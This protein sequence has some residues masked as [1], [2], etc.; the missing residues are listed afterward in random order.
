MKWKDSFAETQI[1]EA[2]RSSNGMGSGTPKKSIMPTLL[3]GLWLVALT[4]LLVFLFMK[5]PRNSEL[6]QKGEFRKKIEQPETV[7]V[8][9]TDNKVNE[10]MSKISMMGKKL[11]QVEEQ[12]RNFEK[13]IG[14]KITQIDKTKD[15]V[16]VPT[17]V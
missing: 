9:M 14:E 4:V 2:G 8:G 17:A 13:S 7:S 16:P 6:I 15:V 10:M 1:G 11:A 12:I 3:V 5:T